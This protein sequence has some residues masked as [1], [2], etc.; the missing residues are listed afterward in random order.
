MR[1]GAAHFR[2]L[3]GQTRRKRTARDEPDAEIKTD[4]A[5]EQDDA[6]HEGK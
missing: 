4:H 5:D 1:D 6:G 2:H 3:I